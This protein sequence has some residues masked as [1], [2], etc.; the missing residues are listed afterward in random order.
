MIIERFELR[1]RGNFHYDYCRKL[2]QLGGLRLFSIASRGRECYV[3]RI[4]V[5]GVKIG[6]IK[7][8]ILSGL[9]DWEKYFSGEFV[10]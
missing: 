7:P 3:E 9:M 10:V 4:S 6:D 8:A 2:G 5:D 1:L